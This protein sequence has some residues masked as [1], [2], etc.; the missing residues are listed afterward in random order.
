M[1]IGPQIFIAY[2]ELFSKVDVSTLKRVCEIGR[3]N[4]CINERI[5]EKIDKLFDLFNKQVNKKIYDLAP[6][7]NWGLRAKI[8]YESL[9]MEYSSIDIDNEEVGEDK[10]SNFELDL[11]YDEIDKNFINKFDFVTNFGTSEHILN[12]L[13]FFKTMHDITR[14]GG[15]MISELPCMFG[16]NHGMFKYEPKFFMDLARA[17][18]YSIVDFY[19]VEDPP[20]LNI[21]RWDQYKQINGC[22][23]LCIIAIMQKLHDTKFCIPLCGN[24]E[25][26]IKNDI[27][28][29]YDYVIQGEII[30]GDQTTHILRYQNELSH[31]KK[32]VLFKELFKRFLIKFGLKKPN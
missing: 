12:Q 17:N 3:Q 30:K 8:L 19:M 25:L 2:N 10:S 31:L 9:G 7:D 29:R 6:K 27:M 18:A 21:Y 13:N 32:E 4:L 24:Y 5:D 22:K 14:V 26:K 20:S 28:E 16:L 11:N 15:Y 23:D 1:G